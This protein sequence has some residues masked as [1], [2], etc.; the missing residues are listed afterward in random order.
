MTDIQNLQ[1][2]RATVVGLGIEGIDLV[3]YLTTEGAIVTVSDIR[4]SEALIK[5]INEI[6]DCA[7]HLSLGK[8]RVEDC[9]EADAV[10]VSQGVPPDLPALRAA[11]HAKIPISSMTQLFVERCPSPIAGITGSSG[12][13]T[14]TALTGAML[15]TARIN[16]VVGGNI[17]IGLLGLLDKI[18]PETKVVT[19]LSHTQLE[20][21]D[22][23]PAIACITNVT[24]NHLDRYSWSSYVNLKRRIFQF[25]NENELAIFN[26][27]DEIC[28][29]FA[30]ESPGHIAYTSVNRD[31]P[32]DGVLIS[33]GI[34]TRR[35][36]GEDLPLLPREQIALRGEHNVANILSA[37]AIASHLGASDVAISEA[38]RNFEGV[39][40]RLEVVGTF[41]DVTYVNDSIATTP[42]RAIAGLRSFNAPIV[43]LLGGRDKHL[44]LRE[45]AELAVERCRT[46]ITFG[47][48]GDLFASTMI[49][50]RDATTPLVDRVEDV[51]SAVNRAA[52]H[53]HKGDVVLFSPAGTSFDSY[54]TFEERGTAFRT[55][56]ASLEEQ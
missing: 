19:E 56:V 1:G 46:I 25:Q 26:L 42:E 6:S 31:I 53:A 24:P 49:K 47:E 10:F 8:N 35:Q 16:H 4:T 21:V 12:K 50:A 45:L 33:D 37:V 38:I 55:A 54:R 28:A 22:K 14:T 30:N 34:L 3:R 36:D 20:T 5:E 17:G 13:T 51:S 44:P 7:P 11:R 18:E 23:S 39:P 40:H 48:S 29:G 52:K 9:S 41:R 43:L 2:A 27:D 32:G 15:D